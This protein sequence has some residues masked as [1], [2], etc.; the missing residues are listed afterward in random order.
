M[1]IAYKHLVRNI[2]PKPNIQDISSK[3]IQLGHEHEVENDIFDMEFTPNRGDC[4]SLLGIQRDLNIFYKI[5]MI[6]HFITII[7][8][9]M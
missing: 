6:V 2:S 9:I 7:F 8:Y 4:L 3:L 5:N 1:K